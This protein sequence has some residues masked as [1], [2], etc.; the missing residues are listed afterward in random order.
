MPRHSRS[1][2]GPEKPMYRVAAYDPQDVCI[3]TLG[4]Y[5]T[6]GAARGQK[7]GWRPRFR[8]VVEMCLPEWIEVAES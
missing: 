6:I 8:V 4:P 7:K 3:A 1:Y 2:V 5:S